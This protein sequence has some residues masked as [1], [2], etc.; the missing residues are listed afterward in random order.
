[1]PRLTEKQRRRNLENI[2]YVRSLLKQKQET[3]GQSQTRTGEQTLEDSQGS[4]P[5]EG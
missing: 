1:M 3:D 5:G 4:D 2:S